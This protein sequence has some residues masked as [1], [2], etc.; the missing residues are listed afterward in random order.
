LQTA[1]KDEST[2]SPEEV[3]PPNSYHF[4]PRAWVYIFLSVQVTAEPFRTIISY[5]NRFPVIYQVDVITETQGRQRRKY[6]LKGKRSLAIKEDTFTREEK[7]RSLL[8]AVKGMILL[9]FFRT[10]WISHALM[11]LL[12]RVGSGSGSGSGSPD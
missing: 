1:E 10:C 8:D 4:S 11:H 12:G 6:V 3:D 9:L 7:A 2:V 5:S